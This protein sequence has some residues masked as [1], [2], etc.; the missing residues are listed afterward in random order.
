MPVVG[1]RG[2]Q[3]STRMQLVNAAAACSVYST[4]YGQQPASL[5]D[6]D[7]NRSNIMFIAWGKSGTNDAWGRP[8]H[9]TPFDPAL[10]YGSVMSYGRDG[11][12]GGTGRDA[13]IEFRFGEG[14]KGS[15]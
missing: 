15:Q 10:G 13:D 5:W 8:I 6:L 9:F 2:G 12:V 1:P 11:R 14:Q 3:P 4:H 7:H